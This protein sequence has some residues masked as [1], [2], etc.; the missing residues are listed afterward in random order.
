[1][2]KIRAILG[3][4]FKAVVAIILEPSI[5]AAII[6]ILDGINRML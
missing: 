3:P 1:M 2:K 6:A 5:V 4:V